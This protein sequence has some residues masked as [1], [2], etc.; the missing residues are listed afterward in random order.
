MFLCSELD[1]IDACELFLIQL[2]VEFS[3]EGCQGCKQVV[4]ARSPVALVGASNLFSIL[5]CGPVRVASVV[6]SVR[7]L[8]SVGLVLATSSAIA[9]V[10]FSSAVATLALGEVVASVIVLLL[11]L[12]VGWGLGLAYVQRHFLRNIVGVGPG[13]GLLWLCCHGGRGRGCSSGGRLLQA[14]LC[15][16]GLLRMLSLWRKTSTRPSYIDLLPLNQ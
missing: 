10:W 1:T 6:S 16:I 11:S 15:Y 2:F 9:P 4:S 7:G 8:A 12:V 5:V 14:W 3:G 13:L